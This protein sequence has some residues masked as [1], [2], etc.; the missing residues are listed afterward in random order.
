MLIPYKDCIAHN[1]NKPFEKVIHIGAHLGEECQDYKDNG[2]KSVIWID[3][4]PNLLEPLVKRTQLIA[5]QEEMKQKYFIS[6]LASVND[7]PKNFYVTNNGQS[8]SMLELGTHKAYYP[9][10]VVTEVQQT[11]TCR[12]DTLMASAG[13]DVV[14]DGYDF[15]NLDI[16]GAELEALKGFGKILESPTIKAVYTEVNFEEVY[17]QAPHI[18]EITAFLGQ[19]GFR[20]V[21]N[22]NTGQKWGDALYLRE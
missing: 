12:F 14:Q 3:A 7:S 11:K 16:Q 17:I 1:K 6:L 2:V 8:S 20:L 15:V 19:Y 22:V 13:I 5:T 9:D 4:N 10:I 21:A 18:D